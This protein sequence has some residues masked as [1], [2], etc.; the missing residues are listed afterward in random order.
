MRCAVCGGVDA[1]NRKA[2]RFRCR[3]CGHE[4]HADGNAAQNILARGLTAGHAGVA[5]FAA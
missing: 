1:G 5:C 3:H 4:A 2:A